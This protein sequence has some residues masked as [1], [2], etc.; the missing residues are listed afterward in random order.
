MLV[1]WISYS[2]LGTSWVQFFFFFFF[3]LSATAYYNGSILFKKIN[4]GQNTQQ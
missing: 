2:A 3:N 4:I 1:I